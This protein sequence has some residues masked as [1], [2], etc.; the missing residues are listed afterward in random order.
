MSDVHLSTAELLRWRDQGAGDRDRIVGHIAM[1]PACRRTAAELE[2]ARPADTDPVR[3]QP[4]DFAATGYDAGERRPVW[5]GVPRLAYLAA[6]AAV[7]LAVLVVP[8]WQRG[9]SDSA[10]RGRTS[11]VVLVRPVDATVTAQDLAFE[12]RASA[13][14]D[15]FRLIVTATDDAATPIV[16]RDVSDTRYVPTDAERAKLQPGR[17]LHWFVEYHTAGTA[18]GTSPA[19]RFRVR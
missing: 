17:Q 2:R 11:P 6:A 7:V 12:W 5:F 16:D 13:G 18:T 15:R 1:C 9:Q 19:A 14:V 3:F 4:S 8:L 10:V